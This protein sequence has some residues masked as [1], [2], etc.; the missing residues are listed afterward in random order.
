MDHFYFNYGKL[1]V[2][3]VWK[4][5]KKLRLMKNSDLQE[6]KPVY[7]RESINSTAD[8]ISLIDIAM[9]L[10]RRKNMIAA[11][12][13]II[14]ALGTGIALSKSKT[15]TFSTSIELGSQVI[16]GAIL[17]FESPQTLLA[18]LQ[19]SFIPQIL[20]EQQLSNPGERRYTISPR[21]PKSSDIIVLEVKGTEDQADLL[22]DLLHQV[23]EK[24]IQDHKRIYEA[25][26]QNYTLLKTQAEGEMALL[27]S[28]GNGRTEEIRLLTKSI[29]T[30][31]SKL[32]NLRNTREVSSP[33]RSIGPTG[34][35]RKLIIIAALAGI[36]A[37]IFSAFFAEF[38]AK[39]KKASLQSSAGS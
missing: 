16:N 35:S 26:K 34:S 12:T 7:I 32:A 30:Y 28:E 10:V 20:S 36:F 17:P 6:L 21:V 13:I 38:V 39:I 11:I 25:V 2:T 9:V 19:Y 31:N 18:K 5:N 14:T 8:E 22:T 15:Y 27:K 1:N 29:D 23:T 37:A 33:I 3:L 4:S 24:T